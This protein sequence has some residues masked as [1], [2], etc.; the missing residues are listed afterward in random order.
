MLQERQNSHKNGA[1]TSGGGRAIY[2]NREK[3]KKRKQLLGKV[4]F[5]ALFILV[6]FLI[7]FSVKK[8]FGFITG[9]GKD[10]IAFSFVTPENWD[11]S[12]SITEI[13]KDY[14]IGIN[15]P[16]INSKTDKTVVND[17]KKM[18]D[19]FKKEIKQFKTGKK[20]NRAVYTTDYTIEKNSD[21]YVSVVY[22]IHR[23]N[24]IREIDDIHYRT[25][26]YNISSGKEITAEEIFDE[27]YVAA[28]SEYVVDMFE[29][30]PTYASETT[31]NLFKQNTRAEISNFSNFS[32]DE[33]SLN[34]HFS[35]GKIFPTDMGHLTIAIPLRR[36]YSHMKINITD[37]TPPVY[38][39]DK[40][41]VALTFDDGPYKPATSIIL[42][43]LE[44]VGGRATFF[45][46][47]ERVANQKEMILRGNE[48]GCEYGNHTWS[49][50]N[51]S[52]AT[53]D[54]ISEQFKKT[55]E[56]LYS[57]IGKESALLRA[58]YAAINDTVSKISGKPFI[59][60]SIDTEDWNK[61]DTE[62]IKSSVLDNISDGD[63][64]L[65]HDLYTSTAN[66]AKDIIHT[67]SKKGFQIV[68]VSELMEA[69]EINLIPGKVH[70]SAK[71]RK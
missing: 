8:L 41:M 71:K 44:S 69:K 7:V 60:W 22:S 40:P 56:A 28:V 48:L 52:T 16:V 24:P 53:E 65:M 13:K 54:E 23:V 47:G 31:T 6:A 50:M 36:V 57:V 20:E 34:L 27:N 26:I 4:V 30:N 33:N 9:F 45:I 5:W 32:F 67:L 66:A 49:H 37:Y 62:A 46:L 61:K 59:G 68:T 1:V 70:Y 55:D 2:I 58:P 51:L 10:D 15:Y 43:A 25:K 29:Q 63:I 21:N 39:P 11:R 3:R 38:D 64:V 12:D 42:D 17:A 18:L 14:A 35:A 19:D